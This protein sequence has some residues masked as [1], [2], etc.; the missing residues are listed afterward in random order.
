MALSVQAQC[1]QVITINSFSAE[2]NGDGTSTVTINISV[3][4]GPGNS[5]VVISYNLNDGLGEIN[6]VVLNDFGDFVDSTFM[7]N[8]PSC[9]NYIVSVTGWTNPSG[10]GTSCENGITADIILPVKFGYFDIS[11]S[12]EDVILEWSTLIETN[13]E[14]FVIQR[15]DA[16]GDFIN[17]GEVKGVINSLR[18]QSYNFVDSDIKNGTFYY[19]LKQIDLDG[20]FTFSDVRTVKINRKSDLL[21]YPIPAKDYIT[22]STS[23]VKSFRVIDVYGKVVTT[24]HNIKSQYKFDISQ[25][26]SGL[27]YL[28]NITNGDTVTFIKI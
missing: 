11:K 25:L 9:D 14:K 2:C 1:M 5:S 21:I 22:I 19:R 12:G 18:E 6:A 28:Q 15:A 16:G 13:N 27:Y 7:F 23:A 8:V 4:F 24:I 20:H 17:L 10:G 26:D 3:E